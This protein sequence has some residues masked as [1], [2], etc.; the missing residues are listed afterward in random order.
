M[1]ISRG[2]AERKE[3]GGR[4]RGVREKS[5]VRLQKKG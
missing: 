1:S 4:L 5:E 2:W 3:L